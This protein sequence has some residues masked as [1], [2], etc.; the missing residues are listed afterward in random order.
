[1]ANTMTLIASATAGSGGTTAFDFTSIPQTYTDLVLKWSV[2]QDLGTLAASDFIYFNGS[3][4][5]Y[6]GR[7]MEGNG[8]GG[9]AASFS[10]TGNWTYANVEGN[11]ASSTGSIF[12][13]AE[14]YIPNYAGSSNKSFSSDGVMETN[15]S[16][17]YVSFWTGLWSNTAA[18]NRITISTSAT[19][20]TG[21][22][23]KFLQYSTAY[24]YGIKNS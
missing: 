6:S 20:V 2:R 15:A 19:N 16:T 13:N 10:Y 12:A 22:A 14:I 8:G 11:G 17:A 4:T 1:M 3:Q 21:G 18:I 9:S 23:Q 5:S 24:L 7:G